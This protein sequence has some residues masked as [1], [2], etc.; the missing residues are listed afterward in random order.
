MTRIYELQRTLKEFE[1]NR[2]AKLRGLTGPE[3]VEAENLPILS[4][5]I[6]EPAVIRPPKKKAYKRIA[7]E[8]KF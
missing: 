8:P 3:K 7:V 5:E 4:T 6:G 1:I 2:E